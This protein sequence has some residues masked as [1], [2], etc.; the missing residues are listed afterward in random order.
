ME[1]IKT[2]SLSRHSRLFAIAD[3]HQDYLF[4]QAKQHPYLEEPYRAE[5]YAI[6]YLKKGSIHFST[7]LL[8]TIVQAPAMITLA[9]SVIRSFDKSSD[10]MEMDIIFF[11]DSFLLEEHADL[12]FL[13]KYDF[14]ENHALHVLP[15]NDQNQKKT[16]LIFELINSTQKSVNYHTSAVI[17]NY[18]FV[19]IYEVD[20]YY[21]NLPTLPDSLANVP[22]LVGRFRQLLKRYYLQERKLEF[23]ASKLHITPKYLSAIMKRHTGR[24]A[25]DWIDEVIILEAKVLLQNQSLNISQ[26]SNQL[27]F[28]DQSIFGKF[29]KANTAISPMAYRKKFLYVSN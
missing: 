2:V 22:S 18:I 29:F 26:I 11:K 15:L 20:A 1:E 10:M 14:F 16:A 25:R 9:P 21:R 6:A 8:H 24:P 27:G 7:G 17:R 4:V 5:S 12:F 28:I 3:I 13:L 23:Y 19:L